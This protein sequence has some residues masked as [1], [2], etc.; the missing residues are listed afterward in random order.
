M[1]LITDLIVKISANTKGLQSGIDYAGRALGN[2]A[3]TAK[4]TVDVVQRLDTLSAA[5]LNSELKTVTRDIDS[6]HSAANAA[7]PHVDSLRKQV[8]YTAAASGLAA[9]SLRIL[10][11]ATNSVAAGAGIVTRRLESFYLTL[12]AVKA[13]LRPVVSVLGMLV[14]GLNAVLWPITAFAKIVYTIGRPF[15]SMAIAIAAFRLSLRTLGIQFSWLRQLLAMLPLRVKLLL[16]VMLGAGAAVQ[17]FGLAGRVAARAVS[18]LLI[19]IVAIRNPMTALK[20]MGGQVADGVLAMA[21]AAS[22]AVGAIR[23]MA[24]AASN[25]VRSGLGRM[26]D[27]VKSTTAS[28]SGMFSLEGATKVIKLAAASATLA[29]QMKVLTG[30]SAKAAET[31]SRL[32]AFAAETPFQ[33]MEIAEAARQLLAF[34]SSSDTVFEELRV[35]GDLAAGTGIPLGELADIYGKNR[36][37]GRLFGE[38]INQLQGRGIPIVAELAK[39]FG[40]NEAEV[41]KL[42]EQGKVG[43]PDMQRALVALTSNGGKFTGM[44]S[45]LSGTTEG[46]FSTMLDNLTLL[47]TKIGDMLLPYANDLIERM[48]ALSDSTGG[49][50]SVLSEGVSVAADWFMSI[51]NY[52][53]ELIAAATVLA[54]NFGNI[55]K[56]MFEEIPKWAKYAFDWILLN[57]GTIAGNIGVAVQNAVV[58]VVNFIKQLVEDV[59]WLIGV[60]QERQMATQIKAKEYASLIDVP[61]P[62]I[63]DTTKGII[64]QVNSA[65]SGLRMER[66]A[67]KVAE[68]QKASEKAA[69]PFPFA[70]GAATTTDKESG[71][72][73]NEPKFA[74]AL[75][76][77]SAEAFSAIVQ[78]MKTDGATKATQTVN[79]TLK[80]DVAGPLKKIAGTMS[81]PTAYVGSFT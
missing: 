3:S 24:S 28:L 54:L 62:E 7:I 12:T 9:T 70:P 6:L 38:D 74:G 49:Y 56:A 77:G 48:I 20:M 63:G 50:L 66:E 34:G 58:G 21:K 16:G 67:N 27:G 25:A 71:V 18:L 23:S 53:Q 69:K 40:V 31:M 61:V 45:E 51:W 42:V 60:H 72:R 43:F 37:Q 78:N 10:F 2:V 68:Q 81:T 26:R 39:Q 47:G 41:K 8:T 64:N 15:I 80:K 30:S 36:V 29:M 65:V 55:W 59:K 5:N 14:S 44:M 35:L 22:R 57:A 11:G 4:T 33:K 46:R 75:Q 79:Q 17:A 32:D 19:P 76:K 13:T 52:M 1:A 73:G